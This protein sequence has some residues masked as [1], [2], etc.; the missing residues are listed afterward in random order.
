MAEQIT[1]RSL[2]A[3][4][5]AQTPINNPPTSRVRASS[6]KYYIHDSC[7]ELRLKLI[8]EMTEADI[9]ELKGCWRTAKTTLAKRKLVLDLRSLRMIDESARDWLAEMSRAG[10]CCLPENFLAT[11]VPGD[12]APDLEAERAARK[13]GLFGRIAALFRGTAVSAAGSST[14]QAQ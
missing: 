6:F 2:R 3:D 1:Q 5:I 7:A 10:A 12:R 14:T 8:G 4:P 11:R 9:A 13:I